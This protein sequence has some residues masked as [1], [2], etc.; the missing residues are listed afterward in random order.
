MQKIRTYRV[1]DVA[2]FAGVSVRTLHHYDAIGLLVPPLRTASGYRLYDEASLFRL[3]QI[4][5]N[6]ELG[7]PLEDIRR[8]LDDT[9]FDYKSALIRQREQLA[10]RVRMATEMIGAIDKA[11]ELLEKPKVSEAMDMKKIFDGFYPEKYE[12]EVKDRW[13]HTDTYKE[14]MRCTQGYSLDDWKIINAEQDSIYRMAGAAMQASKSPGDDDVKEIAEQHR[15]FIDR[16]FYPCSPA[17]HCSLANMWQSDSR[18]SD[19]IDKYGLGL[20]AFLADAVRA[21]AVRK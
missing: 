14:S 17:M 5:I 6:R 11:M 8:L 7:L 12:D 9:P 15:L 10:K 3:Q 19:T 13:G 2:R 20:T 1:K 4:L 21:N 16:R 18:F